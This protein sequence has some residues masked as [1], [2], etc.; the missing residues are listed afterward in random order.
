MPVICE[1]ISHNSVRFSSCNSIQHIPWGLLNIYRQFGVQ[2]CFG[3]F[4]SL[5]KSENGEMSQY[6]ITSHHIEACTFGHL[7][8][9]LTWFC[10]FLSIVNSDQAIQRCIHA[11]IPQFHSHSILS[12]VV[13]IYNPQPHH[14]WLWGMYEP[15]N[16]GNEWKP[17]L[18]RWSTETFHLPSSKRL[19]SCVLNPSKPLP[20]NGTSLKGCSWAPKKAF[21]SWREG[22]GG[23]D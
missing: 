1:W 6:H 7:Y 20:G 9:F 2:P 21:C 22:F 13:H 8:S 3:I 23:M 19:W 17:T 12:N 10:A 14:S 11:H 18:S 4:L 5:K 16:L 15:C